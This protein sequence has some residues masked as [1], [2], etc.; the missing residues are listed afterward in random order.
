MINSFFMKPDVHLTFQTA[1]GYIT[2]LSVL[3]GNRKPVLN[4]LLQIEAAKSRR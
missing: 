3:Q 1:A 4:K 2:G